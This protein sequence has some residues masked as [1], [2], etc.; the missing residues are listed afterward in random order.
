VAEKGANDVDNNQNLI[1]MSVAKT[2]TQVD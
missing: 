1:R 2:Q